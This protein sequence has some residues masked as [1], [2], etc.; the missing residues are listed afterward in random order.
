[1]ELIRTS[2]FKKDLKRLPGE[3]LDR[4]AKS[5]ELFVANSNHPSLHV[6]KMEGYPDIWELRVSENYRVTF[7]FVREGVLLRRVGTHNMLRHP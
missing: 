2:S 4:V 7:Q 5:L 3:V 6:K 1:M